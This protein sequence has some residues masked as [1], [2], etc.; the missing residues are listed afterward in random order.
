MLWIVKI[1]SVAIVITF[2]LL[3][4]SYAESQTVNKVSDVQKEDL[5][6]LL[7]M[8]P[9]KSEFYTDEAINKAQNSMPILFAFSEKDLEKYDIYPFLALSRGLA[10]RKNHQEYAVKHFL[11]IQHPTLK[12]FWGSVLFN[13]NAVSPEIVKFLKGALKLEKQ[14][15]ILSEM[16]GPKYKIFKQQVTNFSFKTKQ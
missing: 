4:F 16:L 8:L 9:V 6:K 3:F 5:I 1:K 15:Q 2:I 14:A 10:D 11:E 13:E 12:L 7:K